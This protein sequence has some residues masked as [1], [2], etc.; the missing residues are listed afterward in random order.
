MLKIQYDSNFCSQVHPVANRKATMEESSSSPSLDFPAC[1]NQ[2]GPNLM[3]PPVRTGSICKQG[4]ASMRRPIRDISP[5]VKNTS[6]YLKI[7]SMGPVFLPVLTSDEDRN[8][9]EENRVA[10]RPTGRA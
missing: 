9:P 10:M 8:G 4:E 6:T 7:T 1:L 3:M 5:Y 2:S